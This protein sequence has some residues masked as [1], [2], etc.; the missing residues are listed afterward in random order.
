MAEAGDYTSR[1]ACSNDWQ[2]LL[3]IVQS[4]PLD[5]LALQMVHSMGCLGFLKIWQLNSKSKY[6]KK[7]RRK[8]QGF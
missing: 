3:V 2:V 4:C 8:L 1:I 6:S 7:S 5:T